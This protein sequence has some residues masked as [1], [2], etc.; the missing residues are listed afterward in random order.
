MVARPRMGGEATAFQPLFH[1]PIVLPV[2]KKGVMRIFGVPPRPAGG[3][4]RQ[5]DD[6]AGNPDLCKSEGIVKELGAKHLSEKALG[7]GEIAAGKT[8]MAETRESRLPCTKLWL[9]LQ[10]S[11]CF[12]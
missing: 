10:K 3:L 5:T 4:L 11:L 1:R 2:D 12:P 6:R 9:P 8:C 7:R